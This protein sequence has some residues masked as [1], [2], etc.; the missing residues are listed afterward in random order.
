MWSRP[1]VRT[2]MR[3]YCP[4]RAELPS[5]IPMSHHRRAVRVLDLDPVPRRAGSIGA[6]R[7]FETIP[8]KPIAQACRKTSSPLASVCSLSAIPGGA[9][10]RSLA[11]R[12]IEFQ[13]VEGLED[14][15]GDA[16]APVERVE[17]GYAVGAG[18][19]RLTPVLG[20]APEPTAAS[21]EHNSRRRHEPRR[22]TDTSKHAEREDCHARNNPDR[23]KGCK[24]PM[25]RAEMLG[26]GNSPKPPPPAQR[27]ARFVPASYTDRRP[28]RS[29]PPPAVPRPGQRSIQRAMMR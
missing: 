13:K 18:D 1:R 25:C 29:S 11:R 12:A 22:K 6:A 7:R 21:R 4:D 26:H 24:G 3:Q 10:A 14:G 28:A 15:I 17:H 5:P 19:H 20:A 9:R 23:R 2:P 8:S 16:A 27:K